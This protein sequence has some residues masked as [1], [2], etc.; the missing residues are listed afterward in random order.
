[1]ITAHTDRTAALQI[2]IVHLREAAPGILLPADTFRSHPREDF[3]LQVNFPA[4][5]EAAASKPLPPGVQDR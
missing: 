4:A 5:A 2:M 1:M 3:L